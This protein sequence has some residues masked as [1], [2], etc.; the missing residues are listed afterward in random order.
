[1]C[2]MPLVFLVQLPGNVVPLGRMQHLRPGAITAPRHLE[3]HGHASALSSPQLHHFICV[4][5]KTQAHGFVVGNNGLGGSTQ[6]GW[7][8]L[9]VRAAQSEPRLRGSGVAGTKMLQERI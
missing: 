1:M 8:R 6:V 4:L 7:E 5:F 3:A 2:S 9:R